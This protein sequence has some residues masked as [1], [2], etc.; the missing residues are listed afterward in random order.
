MSVRLFWRCEGLAL[1]PV[2][3]FSAGD[4]TATA[5][6]SPAIDAGA[7]YV[8][9]G[10][11][12]ANADPDYYSF[13]PAGLV[14]PAEGCVGF[15][16][17]PRAWQN[18]A[19]LF[20]ANGTDPQ[21]YVR[22]ELDNNS[23][24]VV[25]ISSSL[26]TN[27]GLTTGFSGPAANMVVDSW[28]RLVLR[29][30]QATH[31]LAGEVYSSVNRLLGWAEKQSYNFS[32]PVELGTKLAFGI[33]TAVTPPVVNLDNIFVGSRFADPVQDFIGAYS[34]AEYGVYPQHALR[35]QVWL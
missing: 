32:A 11:I 12:L 2:R 33:V 4:T 10:G 9:D 20:E 29:W 22:M 17:R 21:D 35:G 27:L 1:D 16:F 24:L 25:S 5:V 14:D 26:G 30:D 8:G 18:G 31:R 3:D 6:G 13:D 28:Y 15:A 23:E 19:R 7:A 34:F